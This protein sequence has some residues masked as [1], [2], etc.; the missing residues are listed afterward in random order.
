M[1]HHTRSG[2]NFRHF[3]GRK[4][5][6]SI[7]FNS[8]RIGLLVPARGGNL[9]TATTKDLLA[10][11]GHVDLRAQRLASNCTTKGRT[12]SHSEVMIGDVGRQPCANGVV[13]PV[14]DPRFPGRAG[15]FEVPV[16]QTRGASKLGRAR[17]AGVPRELPSL[18]CGAGVT[19]GE[20]PWSGLSRISKRPAFCG[21]IHGRNFG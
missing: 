1:I 19:T 14:P 13:P 15:I 9:S 7:F 21:A 11:A 16:R 10:E 4:L 6:D 3:L 8:T 5:Q 18:R 20:A 12:C 2:N 17:S